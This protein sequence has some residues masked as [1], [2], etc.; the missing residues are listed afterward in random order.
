MHLVYFEEYSY[1]DAARIM[2][3]N[4]KQIDNLL[5]RAKNTLRDMIGEEGE[6]AE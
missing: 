1:E 4:R 6:L 2:K 3:K 5:Y